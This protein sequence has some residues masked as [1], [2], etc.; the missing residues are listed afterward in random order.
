MKFPRNARIFKGQ[1]DAAPFVTVLFL[2][3]LFLMLGTRVYTPGVRLELPGTDKPLP[4]TDS[5]TVAVAID[6]SG[7]LY[8]TTGS[9]RR[10][11]CSSNCG[12]WP[13]PQ[14]SR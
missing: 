9:S 6:A 7:Q 1:L 12:R 13:R 4:G 3:V 8:S 14:P 10:T 2:L 11:G 5:P